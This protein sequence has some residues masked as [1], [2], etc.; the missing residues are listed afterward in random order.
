MA[1]DPYRKAL[2]DVIN[3]ICDPDVRKKYGKPQFL[4]HLGEKI[5]LLATEVGPCRMAPC[6][7]CKEPACTNPFCDRHPGTV[8]EDYLFCSDDCSYLGRDPMALRMWLERI[9]KV[10]RD[11]YSNAHEIALAAAALEAETGE[12]EWGNY[13]AVRIAGE[14]DADRQKEVPQGRP[15][16]DQ[17]APG[18]EE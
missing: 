2:S 10:R 13:I 4:E 3:L 11:A 12:T 17:E 14:I 7:V 9:D 15:E 6:L 5:K 16:G 18:P 8:T 1:D